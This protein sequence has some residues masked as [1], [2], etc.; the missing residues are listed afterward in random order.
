MQVDFSQLQPDLVLDLVESYGYEV[1]GQSY[2][3]NSYENRVF[4][5][6]LEEGGSVIAKFYRPQHWSTQQILE[7]H[8]FA[9]KLFKAGVPIAENI[10]NTNGQSVIE[11][12]GYLCSLQQKVIGRVP[13]LDDLDSMFQLGQLIGSMHAQGKDLHF[14]HRRSFDI[15]RMGCTGSAYLAENWIPKKLQGRYTSI[16]MQLLSA[17]ANC[18]PD[19]FDSHFIAAHGDCHLSNVLMSRDGPVML[20]FDDCMMAP[21]VQDIWMFLAGDQQQQKKQLSELIEGYEE[22]AEFPHYQLEWIPAMRA[23]R[24]INYTAWLARRWSDPAFPLAFPWFNT[25]DYW[26][27]HLKQLQQLVN[28]F[29]A[30][31]FSAKGSGEVSGNY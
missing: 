15:V 7:E 31:Q 13:E 25:E 23:L 12:A 27:Q 6:G 5:V 9:D 19:D 16:I 8:S 10:L 14:K 26:L 21:A 22:S 18:L 11:L 29:N 20:D 30:E 1:S 3:L 24:V 4:Q 17:I 28:D 2:P